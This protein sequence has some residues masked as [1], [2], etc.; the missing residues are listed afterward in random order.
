MSTRARPLA[1]VL[2]FGALSGTTL[3]QQEP[4]REITQ[5]AGVF[6]EKLVRW[7][8]ARDAA[9]C[10]AWAARQVGWVGTRHI[11]SPEARR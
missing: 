4:R 5:I 9:A 10:P 1:L 2:A 3:A 6:C 11:E 7:S 8:S